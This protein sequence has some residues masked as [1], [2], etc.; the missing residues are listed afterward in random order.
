[1]GRLAEDTGR[2]ANDPGVAGI[3][4]NISC[5]CNIL[6]MSWPCAMWVEEGR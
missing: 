6:A 1:M 4:I 3:E 2:I 5:N